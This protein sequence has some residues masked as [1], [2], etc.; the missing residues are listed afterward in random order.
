MNDTRPIGV[1]D[2]GVGGLSV[3]G[4]IRT[5]LPSENLLYVADS[6]FAPYGDKAETIV[7]QRCQCIAQFLLS[8]NCK[9]IVIACNTA[10]AA[11]ATPL[12]KSLKVPVIALEPGIKPAVAATKTGV[13]GILA[14]EGT[15]ASQR[16][17]Q[18]GQRYGKHVTIIEQA[19]NGL[20]EQIERGEIDC[21]PTRQIIQACLAPFKI[22]NVDTIV[23]GCTHFP[24]IIPLIQDV[25]GFPVTIIETGRAVADQLRRLLDLNHLFSGQT[26]CGSEHFWSSGDLGSARRVFT[27]LWGQEV[28]VE[29]LVHV[30][31]SLRTTPSER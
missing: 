29:Q 18:L 21:E 10:T 11:A 9:A 7:Q 30:G 13:I 25:M 4:H 1:F 26:G 17:N 3:L 14:T 19:C 5:R 23:L 15:L 20:V 27:R 8:H 24:F 2:S 16:Y 31:P 6:A 28:N 22:G 12:R